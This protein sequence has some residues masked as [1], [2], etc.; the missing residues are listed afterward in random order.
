MAKYYLPASSDVEITY[1]DAR[2][3]HDD[4]IFSKISADIT[5]KSMKETLNYLWDS[6]IRAIFPFWN[7]ILIFFVKQ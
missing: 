1:G 4:I 5:P 7:M 6:I 3:I 2:F